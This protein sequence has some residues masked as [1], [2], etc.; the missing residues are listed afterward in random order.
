MVKRRPLKLV[1]KIRNWLA[2]LLVTER[3]NLAALHQLRFLF[4]TTLHWRPMWYWRQG[5][6]LCLILKTHKVISRPEWQFP[7]GACT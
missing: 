7:Q 5:M 4:T 3:S 6:A 1:E 2:A